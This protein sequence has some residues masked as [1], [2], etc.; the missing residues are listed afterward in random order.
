[1]ISSVP[2]IRP[3]N[4][5]DPRLTPFRDVGD[6]E[7]RRQEGLFLAEGRLIVRR[8]LTEARYRTRA[9]MVSET[10]HAA[11]DDVLTGRTDALEV[12]VVPPAWMEGI[13]GFNLHRGCLAIGER[14]TARQWRDLADGAQRL[15]VLEGVGNSDNVGGLFRTAR[16]FGV[17][18]VLVGPGTGDPLYRKAIRVS[19]GAALAL[20]HAEATPWPDVLCELVADGLEVWALTPA[21]DATPLEVAVSRGVPPRLAMLVG[22]EGPGL[23]GASL[24]A[25]SQRIRVPIAPEADSLNVT[26]AAGIALAAVARQSQRHKDTETHKETYKQYP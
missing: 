22:A 25:A 5:D 10:A 26:V 6:A 3:D 1:M 23:T 13:T 9:V 19:C 17:D 21:H 24:A 4:V 8:L 12:F 16:A 2:V 18:A 15:L 20:P 11:L 7:L 14:G